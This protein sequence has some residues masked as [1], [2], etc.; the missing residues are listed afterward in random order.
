MQ[1]NNYLISVFNVF[2]YQKCFLTSYSVHFAG[3]ERSLFNFY[4]LFSVIL[5][6]V[7]LKAAKKTIQSTDLSRALSYACGSVSDKWNLTRLDSIC[8]GDKKLDGSGTVIAILDTAIDSSCF[9][10]KQK[11]S[12]I[13]L[14]DFLKN[15]PV[16]SRDHGTICSAVAVGS[17]YIT[18]SGLVIPRGVAPG[19]KLVVYRIADK[20]NG[21]TNAILNAL[22]DIK[23]KGSMKVD[24]VSISYDLDEKYEVEIRSKIGELTEMGITFVA[25]AGNRG[26][27]QP[28]ACIPARF[29][30][31]ISVGALDVNGKS[32]SYTPPV[33][34][35]AYAPGEFL[36]CEGTSYATP[37]VAGLVLLLKQWANFIGSPAKE[38]INRVDI[39]RKIFTE[40]MFV[41]SYGTKELVD[42]S[43]P[44]VKKDSDGSILMFQP[45]DFFMNMKDHPEKL[46]N[47]IQKHLDDIKH[48]MED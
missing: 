39:L 26:Y 30:N 20:G 6:T 15:A 8:L 9:T 44:T 24:V 41:K 17:P 36:G 11:F 23:Q 46:N 7:K 33:K 1:V 32:T 14:Y 4:L 38:N 25:A 31:V 43:Q 28:Q 19:A 3:I 13:E 16:S 2:W 47:T 18:P 40:D 12:H 27:Y 35:D 34:L 22:E 10:T 37:A 42:T 21:D 48:S 5:G 29:D 45:V